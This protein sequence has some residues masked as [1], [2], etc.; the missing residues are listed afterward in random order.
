VVGSI[1]HCQ[2]FAA[3]AVAWSREYRTVGIDA[4]PARPLPF[5]V[6]GMVT[7]AGERAHLATLPDDVPWDTVLFCAKESVYKA[8]YP[9]AGT[10]LGFE[11]AEVSLDPRGTFAARLRV[12]GPVTEFRGRF[13]IRDGLV[14]TTIAMEALDG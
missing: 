11:D 3:V 5:G 9:L 2:G 6:Q 13:R 1:T 8:W 7:D 14:L 12:P 4:E 10:W